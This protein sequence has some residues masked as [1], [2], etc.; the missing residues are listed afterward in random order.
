[1]SQPQYV[2]I[3][4]ERVRQDLSPA[5]PLSLDQVGVPSSNVNFNDQQ[6]T[7]FRIENRTT[8]PASPLAGQIWLRTDL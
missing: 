1:M 2:I 4:G 6:A 3:H 8:D 7:S 5:L